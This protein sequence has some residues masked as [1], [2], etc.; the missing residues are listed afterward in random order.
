MGVVGNSSFPVRTVGKTKKVQRKNWDIYRLTVCKGG[1]FVIRMVPGWPGEIFC[2]N[3][4]EDEYIFIITQAI[5]N[6]ER[7]VGCN[8]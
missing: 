1:I 7:P 3:Y 2:K 4:L 6:H 5:R 8:G